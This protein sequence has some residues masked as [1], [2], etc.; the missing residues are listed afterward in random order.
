MSL[1]FHLKEEVNKVHPENQTT[2]SDLF[3]MPNLLNYLALALSAVLVVFPPPSTAQPPQN[4]EAEALLLWKQSLRNQT[5]VS[6]WIFNQT[7]GNSSASSPC[8]WRGISCS[9]AGNVTGLNLAYTGLQGT[10]DHLNFS[11]FPLLLRL[12][13]KVNRLNGTIPTN[14]GLLSNLVY[15][16]LSTNSFSGTIPLSVA[17]LTKVVELDFSRN[18]ITGQLDPRLFPDRRSSQAKTGL[19]SLQ[20][21]L[22]QDTLLSG[23]L[24]PEIGNLEDLTILALDNCR[25]SGP[26][27]QSL[28]NLSKI[29]F[30]HLNQNGFSGQIPKSFGTLTKLADLSLF[31][32]NLSGSVPEEIG[33]LSSLVVFH[34]IFNNLSGQLP[35]QVCQG[36]VLANFTAGYNNFTGPIPVSLKNCTSLYRVRL[37]YNQLTG[38]LDEDFGAYPNLTYIDLSNNNLQGKILPT[39]GECS[40]LTRLSLGGNSIGGEIPVEISQLNQLVVLDFSSNKITG[41]IPAQVGKLLKLLSLNLSD[42]RISGQIPSEIGG[43]S[44]LASLDLSMNMLRGPIPGQIGD[45]SRLLF[46]SLS[47][48]QLNGSIPYQIGNLGTL[49]SLL[50]L[51]DNSLTGE[52]SPQLGKLM[53]LEALNLSHNYLSGSIPDSFS[54][55]LS[56]STIDLS[57]N[58]LEG[59]L[60]DSK[61]FN[62]SPPEAFSHNK[63]LCGD[64]IQ[65]LTPCNNSLSGGGG[66]KNKG[67]SRLIIIAVSTSLGSLFLLLLLVGA[68]ALHRKSNRRSQKEDGVKGE[69][70]F[71]IQ[72]FCGR[73]VY[74]D[75][76]RATEN[77]DDAYCIGHGG[78]ARVYKVNLPSGQVVAVKK[79]FM[80]EGSEI[81]EIKSF[82]NEVATLTEIRH[83]NIVKLYGFCY[84]EKHMF[85]VCEYMERG[86]LADVLRREKDA[87]ELDWS[88]RV[89]V[90]KGVAHALS[91]LHHNCAP[92]IIHRDISSKNVLLDSEM[93]AH[94]SDFGT[95]RFLKPDSSNWTAVVGTFGYIAPELS[96]TMAVT[97]KCDVYSFG[98]L[99]L[100]ILMG[101]HPGELSSNLYSSVDNERIQL[102]DVLDPRLPPP[103]SQKLQD[104]LDSILNL[105]VWC[106]RVEPHSRP[107]MYDASQMPS[108]RTAII[109]PAYATTKNVFVVS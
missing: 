5:I 47:K 52:I 31:S 57:F 36:G 13:L 105:A 75:I 6:S 15:L 23:P 69:D 106:L 101:S 35:P 71:L 34:L 12:D 14:I 108:K 64:S 100:E 24:P 84:H 32:N 87:R 76:I 40:N 33:N 26:I 66:K 49:Q 42:N 63:N 3:T 65:G 79:L 90:V 85:L 103:T 19:L 10:L 29:T 28:G 67:N 68:I 22:F 72:N 59:P 51:S 11:Y 1:S 44:N 60:P 55:M 109:S 17:N 70:I 38:N 88:K 94:V 25:F 80:N 86:S 21:L 98:V 89:N 53:S 81:G 43:L 58:E 104:E 82:A 77:F 56:L 41:K 74:G 37:E 93:E 102:A 92:P 83:R 54:G 39:W 91:Y 18:A 48:N 62:S 99:T 8:N 96:Y 2:E 46:L 45:I 61:V 78:S 9:A 27:P 20:R 16:D 4:P 107:T 50:D 97:E 73:I 30:L 95:A 7:N